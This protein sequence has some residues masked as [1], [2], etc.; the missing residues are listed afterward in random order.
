MPY[1]TVPEPAPHKDMIETLRQILAHA[2]AG[3]I[4]G[5]AFACVLKRNR[6]ITDVAGYC[7]THPTFTRGIVMSLS[8]DLGAMMHQ[9]APDETR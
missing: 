8:D 2:E 9:S 7:A 1:R 3:A 6:Y 4:T 5:I